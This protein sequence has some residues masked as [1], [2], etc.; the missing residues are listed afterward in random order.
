M[1]SSAVPELT[2][3]EE[4]L[5]D[6]TATATATAYDPT[7]RVLAIGHDTGAISLFAQKYP[8]PSHIQ[9]PCA[10]THLLFVP[11]HPA[12]AA[13][14]TNGML[15]IF[16]LCTLCECFSYSVPL[17][18]S[19]MRGIP[20][21]TWLLVGTESGRVYFVD[22]V[23]G[24]KSDFSLGCLTK[25][26]VLVVA[27]ESHPIEAEKVLVAYANGVCVVC[28]M[29]KAEISERE[30]VVSKHWFEHLEALGSATESGSLAA[31]GPWLQSAGWSPTGDRFV[32]TYSNGVLAVFNPSAGSAPIVAR[33]IQCADIRELD[34][35][36]AAAQMDRS[37][38]SL[39]HVRW[40]THA[41]QDRSFLVVT[42]GS[43]PGHQSKIHILGTQSRDSNVKHSHDI[44]VADSF[45]TDGVVA[46]STVPKE[47]PWRNG[48][49]RVDR[50][51]V[52]SERH[53]RVRMLKIR[54]DL[55]LEWHNG[56]PSEL[57]W[58]TAQAVRQVCADG[59]LS[60]ALSRALEQCNTPQL[61]SSI[62]RAETSTRV[63]QLCCCISKSG[64]M[65]LWCTLGER[66]YCYDETGLDVA[67]LSRLIGA[68]GQVTSASLCGLNGLLALG[69][70]TGETIICVLTS[71][72]WSS[73][74]QTYTKFDQLRTTGLELFAQH[75]K[76]H[77]AQLPH[78]HVNG[79]AE[80][81]HEKRV[82][83]VPRI[84]S[85][86][87]H[88]GGFIRR[89][90]KRL[91]STVGTLF[92]RGS[93]ASGHLKAAPK[94]LDK[95]DAQAQ[96]IQA[97]SG[98][99]EAGLARPLRIDARVWSEQQD[100]VCK[101]IKSMVYG[102]C[103]DVN[104]QQ[105]LKG[106]R[107]TELQSLKESA[108]AKTDQMPRLCVQ[109]FMLARFACTSVAS[110]VAGQNGLVAILYHNGAIAVVDVTA[111]SVVLVDNINLEPDASVTV[112]DIFGERAAEP[113]YATTATFATAG[114]AMQLVVGTSEGH[115][116]QYILHDHLQPKVVARAAS[117]PITY[118]AI[119]STQGSTSEHMVV[120]TPKSVCVYHGMD[121]KPAATFHIADTARI[122]SMRVVRLENTRC[123]LAVDNQL[124]V[125]VLKLPDLSEAA[126]LD[127][128]NK[129]HRQGR[130]PDVCI[131]D[132][133][134]IQILGSTGQLAHVRIAP[135][136]PDFKTQRSY[137]DPALS[138]PP[139][140][141]R[142]GI[143]SWLLGLATD[144]SSDINALL[145]THHRDLLS[146][147]GTKPGAHLCE[148]V[149]PNDPRMLS[150]R[151]R[152]D[153]KYEQDMKVSEV[154]NALS[155]GEFMETRDMLDKRG[156]QLDGVTDTV[157]QLSL[158]SEGFLNKVR[159]YNAEQERK[160]KKRF[161]LF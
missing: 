160:S 98:D 144:P 128:P 8:A 89:K 13:L 24:R 59:E 83:S 95:V 92:R 61:S 148:P 54:P 67:Y 158:Q 63:P 124:C 130:L 100:R 71:D 50:L 132:N 52:L 105:R 27:V 53:T 102:L 99:V 2:I 117:G 70:H 64:M 137:F 93:S 6:P 94:D 157:Q 36:N 18:P 20:G 11:G 145:G 26:T 139:Q 112:D 85:V 126:R 84:R 10:I 39:G 51:V 48:N 14:D 37:L 72:P 34:Q 65:S 97:D 22:G 121:A 142:T 57:K 15:R 149:D 81:V 133:G 58:C 155:G 31:N 82:P 154:N 49:D 43:S 35:T 118:L 1:R 135:H 146:G 119:E 136:G 62:A 25:P 17:V 40:C 129:V 153:S 151:S 77:E 125:T 41:E 103:F 127:L 108:E 138:P 7:H 38:L 23:N 30:M 21:T 104:E 91:S 73:L 147:G 88:E 96:N 115:V 159:A 140:P 134:Q 90:S 28:D 29:G 66:L 120:G 5:I 69:T 109:P 86:S 47:S 76:D 106:R 107:A 131:G 161:N 55:R 114:G 45:D 113:T 122:T 156:K 3:V 78:E 150:N 44:S 16:D 4:R 111:Q 75:I 33:T 80:S 19:Y 68:E 143:T 152:K 56:L 87:L 60:T 9:A 116:F 74:A 110:V 101:E 42:S 123:V 12:L 141:K 79:K 32:A 46:I